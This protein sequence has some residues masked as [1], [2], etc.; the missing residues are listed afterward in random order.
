MFSCHGH[1]EHSN[2]R[3]RDA[4]IKVPDFI[5]YHKKCGW[6]GCV[7][8]EHET[9]GSH[10]DVLKY[11][12]SIKDKL[13]YK[14]FKVGLGNEIYLCPESV[15]A[16]N[17]GNNFYPHFILIAL[18]AKG[19][20]A[21]RELSTKAW[22]NNSFMSVMY[23]VPTYYS[24]LQELLEKYKGHLIGSSACLG[25]SV[26]RQL[27]KYR[28][29]QDVFKREEIYENIVYWIETMA[30][31]FGNGYF[32]LEIQ[33]NPNEDQIYVNQ[34][35][36]KLSKDL[37][38]PYIITLD[39]HYLRKEDREIHKA[40]LKA[41]EGDREVDDFYTTTYIMTRDEIHKYMDESIGYDAVELGLNNT[42]LIYDKIQYYSL[43]KDLEL[44]Y[45]PFDLTEPDEQLYIKYKDKIPLLDFFY[46]SE[47][48]SDRHMTRELLRSIDG[49]NSHY[50]CQR[51]YEMIDECLN[52][53]KTSSEV[54]KVRWS[55]YLM[56]VRD[57]VQLAWDA[58]SLVMPS[59]GSGG[60]FCLLYLLDIIQLDALR[61][62]TKMYP[63][64]FLNPKR[65]SVLDIDTDIESAKREAVIQKFI[66]TYGSDRVSK[67]ATLQTEKSK[68][69]ILTAARGLGISN[70]R[71]SYI[72]SLVIFD[73][74]NARSLHTMY[75]G[76]DENAP[77]F[78]FVNE[79]NSL[80]E[81]WE[82]AQKIEGL[83]SGI[84]S[85][86]GGIIICDKPLVE[87]T[88]LMRTNSGDIITQFDLHGDEAVSLIKIDELSVDGAD[89]L[90]ATLNLLLKDGLIK[91]QGNLKDTYFKYLGIYNITRD[92][93][94]L[95]ELV[96]NQKVMNL[97]QFDKD[98]G[99]KALSLVKPH[100]IDDLATINSVIRLMP[101]TKGDEMPLEKYARFH[102][103]IQ[104]WYD[105]M[106]EYGLTEEEQDIL[107][108]IIGISYGICEA[109]EY[110]I[111][112]TMHPQIGGFDLGWADRLR[113]AVAKKSPKDFEQLEVEFFK[114]A[115]EKNLSPNLTNYVWYQLIYTQ[116]GYGF[117]KAHTLGYS[118]I[119]LQEAWLNYKYNPIYWQTANLIVRSGSYNANANDATD[120]DK[121]AVAIATIQS[122][123]VKI[124]NPDINNPQF[125][126][127]P[128][129]QDEKI[130]FSMKGINGVNTELA[131]AIIQNAPYSSMD[132]FA[133]RM[134]D[135][136][137][138]QPS[139]MIKLIKGGCFLT[140]HDSDRFKTMEWFLRRYCFKPANKLTMQQLGKLLSF[141]I[142]PDD[143][144]SCLNCAKI[145]QYV[146]DDEGLYKL[147][148]DPDKKL[149][150]RG[151][152]DRYFI[153]DDVSQ[154]VFNKFFSEGS[155]VDVKDGFYIISE[156]EFI[157]EYNVLIQPLRD[158]FNSQEALDVY[159]DVF[160]KSVWDEKASGSEASWNME[161]CCYYDQSH[162][163]ANVDEK[164]YGIVN[165][166][167]LPE[168]PE[169]YDWYNRKIDGE[170]K[171]VPKYRI[172]RIAG[173]VLQSVNN[174][175]S[176]A[177]LTCYGVVNVKFY[178]GSYA[179]Y[180]KRISQPLEN[181]KKKVLEESWLKRGNKLL[182]SG[183][184]RD[185]QFFP[186][187]YK[188]TIYKHTV[189]LI[190]NVLPD[191]RMELQTERIQI[192]DE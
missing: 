140:L 30:E 86:A 38:I 142:I 153:L 52:Y 49:K 45:I 42:M 169:P 121:M 7:V 134:L 174:K 61:E 126:F 92:A 25:G 168:E 62:N 104:L 116:R 130:E 109:Q 111:L 180:N 182:I 75:Y 192:E 2:Y 157:K 175:H 185:D 60:G 59:R 152:H 97:F 31:W 68:S 179:F 90:H 40:F 170:W 127:V 106:T 57:Y 138:I 183:I 8:T 46:H 172:T 114:N 101:Q 77:V 82:V 14:D 66:D 165:Y 125:E 39:A 176:I 36:I 123:G 139:Q 80:P 23:R 93:T 89:L 124:S 163:L 83:I 28:D 44:P 144:K 47:Y 78:E 54:N 53:L 10:L 181:G 22:V 56:Q 12:N 135:T 143:L 160:F 16:D 6:S 4:I 113:K 96:G 184:R 128:N 9:I 161:A 103:N 164:Y 148:I 94:K 26:P 105:E 156:K 122:E 18:D 3:L 177:L 43:T 55:R 41:A 32:F 69:A 15:T 150:K 65:V 149:P 73:R 158:W 71:A 118:C 155:V 95:W 191:G 67:V 20:K 102:D 51:G 48:P 187:I 58:G 110:L 132:D 129:V 84:G 88:A 100:S 145:K 137:I 72:A 87:S 186:L 115:E 119:G 167:D 173:T 98:S 1:T 33:P 107:K 81:L 35:I 162:E 29:E 34:A 13:E 27:I 159:N 76:D 21:I 5:E 136:K 112:L 178:K 166:F 50:Q 63:W 24:D 146:L 37:Q 120:Y 147:Y 133:I 131:Q 171:R 74:G 190:K 154:P 151:Y 11:Y 108:D 141:R 91:W 64:R 99:K 188:D 17:K 189:N 70:D 85:H 79:M 117:N 19:H